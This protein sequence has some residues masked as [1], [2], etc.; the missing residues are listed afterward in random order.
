MRR[1]NSTLP[2][3]EPSTC[4][5]VGLLLLVAEDR[6]AVRSSSVVILSSFKPA[7]QW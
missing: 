3:L 1:V 7:N 2:M 5:Y 6:Q 4:K